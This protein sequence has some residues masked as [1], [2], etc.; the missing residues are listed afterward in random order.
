MQAAVIAGAKKSGKTT[1]LALIAEALERLGKTVAVVK[2][3]GHAIEKGNADAYW[4]MRPNRTVVNV[5]PGE[6]VIFWP[7]QL[8]FEALISH[9][10]AD[11]VLLEGADA[12]VYVPRVLC[13][14]EDEGADKTHLACREGAYTILAVFGVACA[15]SNAP[16]FDE[17][18]PV[19][20]A[21]VASLILQKSP[22]I[23]D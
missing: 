12:P 5:S 2:Y 4:L 16:F 11:V 6:T 3:S 20:A 18:E 17:M 13:F 7:E 1:I 9:L 22:E 15:A 8:S 14:R 19:A 23:P 10:E 21:Q